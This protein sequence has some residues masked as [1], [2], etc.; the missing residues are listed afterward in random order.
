MFDRHY[1]A[2]RSL[3]PP[4]FSV[5][6]RSVIALITEIVKEICDRSGVR[7]DAAAVGSVVKVD[8]RRVGVIYQLNLNSKYPAPVSDELPR[9]GSA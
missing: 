8:D 1:A 7:R 6:Y 3:D 9:T 2:D 5:I 4:R